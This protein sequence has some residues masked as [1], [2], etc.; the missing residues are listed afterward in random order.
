MREIFNELRR[1]RAERDQLA[2]EVERLRE[3]R[4]ERLHGHRTRY[5]ITSAGYA[6]LGAADNGE[7]SDG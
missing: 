5:E 2:A 7:P 4:V 6:A 1:T 3:S